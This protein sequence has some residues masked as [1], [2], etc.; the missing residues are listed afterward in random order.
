MKLKAVGLTCGIGS[1]LVGARQAGF[2]V[3]G[4]IEWRNYYR[5]KDA[6]GKNTFLENFGPMG[7]PEP[8]PFLK[9]SITDL[10][11]E[12]IERIMGADLAMGHPEC[13]NF[14]TMNGTNAWRG[15]KAPKVTDAGDIPLF[16]KLI[17]DIRPRF[18]AMD[19]LP[20]SFIAYPMEEYAKQLPDYDLWP[21]WVSNHGYGNIQVHR[22]RMFMIGA[23]KEERFTFVPGEFRHSRTV[24]ETIGDLPL[25]PV[26]GG[27]VANHDPHSLLAACGRGLHMNHLWHR[28]TYAEMQEWFKNAPIGK[29]FEYYSTATG[30]KKNKPGWYKAKWQGGAPVMDGGSGH[31]HPMRNLPF[32]IRERARI[33]GFPDDFVFY[34]TRFEDDGWVHEK[35]IDIVKQTGKAMPIQFNR[36]FA[37]L[38]RCHVEGT[39][40]GEATNTRVLEPNEYVSAA[41]SWYCA[42]VGYADQISSCAACWLKSSCRIKFEKYGIGSAPAGAFAQKPVTPSP[43]V[44]DEGSP[45]LSVEPLVPAEDDAE[46]E[47]AEAT[48][49]QRRRPA[50][51]SRGLKKLTQAT[52]AST[53][54]GPEEPGSE[55]QG[56]PE[57][58]GRSS[59][60][61]PRRSV[62]S[63][64]PANSE[65]V[66]FKKAVSNL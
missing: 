15:D 11:P 49:R 34:G 37:M 20:K 45:N 58:S 22:K 46:C 10:T 33:Q 48:A 52:G 5:K 53:L 42:N 1:M 62:R 19:D 47:G 26:K 63:V 40:F 60:D 7:S 17:H 31:M 32:T 38:V 36:Y 2:E 56:E 50:A 8:K 28:P 9:K 3:L 13:G 16:T 64:R 66:A 21:E 24:E 65:P 30:E 51:Q 29:T 6:D 25:Y 54:H 43:A 18:F 23:R 14:S 61:A 55:E 57:Q 59:S 4:N 12:E 41:K 44:L 27:N 39:L 35:N